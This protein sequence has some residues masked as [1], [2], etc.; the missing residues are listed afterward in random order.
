MNKRKADRCAAL[1]AP[2]LVAR[3]QIQMIEATQIG[4]VSA[5]RQLATAVIAGI[6][7]AGT[8]MVTVRPRLY[9]LVLT[10]L[11]LFLV[12]N[13]DGRVGKKI[14]GVV[15]REAISAG[16]LRGHILTLSMEVTMEGVPYRFGW[17][18]AQVKM[19][20]RV[21]EALAAPVSAPGAEPETAAS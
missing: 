9:F 5:K 12:E 14:L 3:E 2:E 17:G 11:R 4:K 7:S 1:V 21:A 18:R 16:P 6:A 10:D 8:L 20:R 13:N 19:A 15:P